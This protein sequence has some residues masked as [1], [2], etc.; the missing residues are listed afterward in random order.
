M[1]A[2]LEGRDSKEARDWKKRSDSKE[3]YADR[4]G[5]PHCPSGRPV[6][7]RNLGIG[8]TVRDGARIECIKRE[9]ARE[10]G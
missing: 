3:V 10:K 4:G 2:K 9:G 6:G 8:A 7:G 5:I 1:E